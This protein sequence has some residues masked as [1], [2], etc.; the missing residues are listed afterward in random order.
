VGAP[1]LR[2]HTFWG[3]P[4]AQAVV[5]AVLSALPAGV[6]PR[7][8]C[9]HLWLCSPPAPE[10]INVH[11][12][13]VVC[14]AALS[15][16]EYGRRV[17]WAL[18][19]AAAAEAQAPPPPPAANAGR[20]LS[21]F[22]AWGIDPPPGIAAARAAEAEEADADAGAAAAA[23][24]SPVQRA[25]R[26]AVADF[27]ARLQDFTTLHAEC[28]PKRWAGASPSTVPP[29]CPAASHPFMQVIT[30]PAGVRRLRLAVPGLMYAGAGDAWAAPAAAPAAAVGGGGDDAG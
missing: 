15:A 7:F 20:Q 6:Q 28:K 26:A 27:W 9:A 12:W 23:A 10:V 14:L 8:L 29:L 18:H 4:V 3:C 2:Q 5:A 22:E 11:V 17:M 16:M 25:A 24:A 19:L 21:L 1:L 13:R 30:L